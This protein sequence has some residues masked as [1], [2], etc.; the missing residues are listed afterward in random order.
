MD[1]ASK[2]APNVKTI[3]PLCLI[4]NSLKK[5]LKKCQ[6]YDNF[7]VVIIEILIFQQIFG[8]MFNSFSMHQIAVQIVYLLL[9][10]KTADCLLYHYGA[11]NHCIFNFYYLTF[12]Y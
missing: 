6:F 12:Q 7:S 3:A 4:K 11:K 10:E 5:I 1:F 8:V 2:M 9:F